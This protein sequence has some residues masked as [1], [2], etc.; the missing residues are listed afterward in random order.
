MCSGIKLLGWSFPEGNALKDMIKE[1]GVYPVTVL[2]TLTKAEK[3]RLIESGT[4]M[5]HAI[6]ENPSVLE[7]AGITGRKNQDIIAET[8]SVCK[9]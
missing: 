2:T 4:T 3:S 7:R 8:N 1:T 9:V 5:C 6:M